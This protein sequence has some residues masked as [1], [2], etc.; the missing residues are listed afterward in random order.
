MREKKGHE[1]RNSA[2]TDLQFHWEDKMHSYEMWTTKIVRNPELLEN[3]CL[4]I[5]FL[6]P[7]HTTRTLQRATKIPGAMEGL[8]PRFISFLFRETEHPSQSTSPPHFHSS[9]Q[10]INILS[11][12]SFIFCNSV[13]ATLEKISPFPLILFLPS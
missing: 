11:A 8:P 4:G 7:H 1:I 6:L 13:S 2:L 9:Y 5:V 12:A 10:L 3:V